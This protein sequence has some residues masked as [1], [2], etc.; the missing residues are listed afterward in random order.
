M[1]T[2]DLPLQA[3][4]F[5][6]LFARVGAVMMM[7]PVFSEESI[8]VQAR[9][10]TALGMTAGLWGLLQ[11]A[12]LP[13]ARDQGALPAILITELLVGMGLGTMI[14]IMFQAAA[15]AASII[16]LQTGLSSAL[17][18]DASLGG[19]A[20]VITKLVSVAAAIACMAMGV[21]HLWIGALIH[22][23]RLFPVGAMPPAADFATLAIATLGKATSL[24]ISL[25]APLLVYGLVF[26]V[27]LGMTARLAPTLQVFFIAQPLNIL[28]GLALFAT[29]LGAILTGFAQAMADWMQSGWS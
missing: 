17:L 16:S 11:P 5:L 1:T 13:A 10:L 6:I 2:F 8:P 25:A 24:S 3:T 14:R 4:T 26:N 29:V 20:T 9:L 12:M 19:Q 21:H 27:A 28:L 15:M 7:L 22:S 23:Y 18:T